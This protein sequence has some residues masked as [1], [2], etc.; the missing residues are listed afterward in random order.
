[1]LEYA[2]ILR[3]RDEEEWIY[4]CVSKLLMQNILPSRLVLVDNGSVDRTVLAFRCAVKLA[5]N[6]GLKIDVIN[7]E[8]YKPGLAI[9]SGVERCEEEYIICLSPHCIP[10]TKN[11]A[12]H[13]IAPLNDSEQVAAVYGRQLPTANTPPDD[14]RDLLYTFGNEDVLWKKNPFLHNAN[15]AYRK[16]DLLKKP[17]DP[18]IKHI[19][20]RIWAREKIGVGER[21]YYSSEAA[22]LH[23]HGLHQHGEN[24]SFRS[25]GLHSILKEELKS[26]CG[27]EI[28]M[29]SSR[30]HAILVLD[31][32]FS[33]GTLA[34]ELTQLIA[35]GNDVYVMV[36]AGEACGLYRYKLDEQ[37][38]LCGNRHENASLEGLIKIIISVIEGSEY[39]EG[40]TVIKQSFLSGK[41]NLIK[42]SK[43]KLYA[44]EVAR[45][46]P[47]KLTHSNYVIVT[48]DLKTH[49]FDTL[50]RREAK[51]AVYELKYLLGFSFRAHAVRQTLTDSEM[52]VMEIIND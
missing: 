44:D 5:L 47:A 13:L 16:L 28:D 1:V 14:F 29:V 32:D 36:A 12:K 38:I 15:A 10:L 26:E 23:P 40:Y 49:F 33:D 11:W 50:E 51:H 24:K 18:N 6:S 37:L 43:T 35:D 22:V 4:H 8:N 52:A 39:Y 42:R 19:E 48:P 9:N 17:F 21:I 2:V 46:V 7:L 31:G 30:K 45:V 3:A 34:L 25:V 27:F 20:D 41:T